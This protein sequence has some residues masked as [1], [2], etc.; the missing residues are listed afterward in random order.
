[1]P[2]LRVLDIHDMN[3]LPLPA[4][5]DKNFWEDPEEGEQANKWSLTR[6]GNYEEQAEAQ[7]GVWLEM[8]RNFPRGLEFLNMNAPTDWPDKKSKE[9]MQT[10]LDRTICRDFAVR[11]L[12]EEALPRLANLRVLNMEDWP[13][14]DPG[15]RWLSQGLANGCAPHA[16]HTLK[17]SE[18]FATDEVHSLS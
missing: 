18:G 5:D 9:G 4:E 10:W 16:L 13:I 11:A 8:C 2:R 3:G 17:L 14:G 15:L 6:F 7:I 12:A 1:M